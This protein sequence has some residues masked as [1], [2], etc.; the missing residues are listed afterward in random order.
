MAIETPLGKVDILVD[1][2]PVSYSVTQLEPLKVLCPDV[3]KR[4]KIEVDFEPDGKEHLISCILTPSQPVKGYSESGELLECYGYYSE[5]ETIKVSIGIEAET[6]YMYN[7]K[8][9][10]IRVCDR[11]DYDGEFE[12]KNGVFYNSYWV[13][14]IT[15]TSHYVFGIAWIL[16]CN[17][18]TDFQTN[19]G[20]DPTIM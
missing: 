1:G 7:S 3:D 5:D 20:A 14:P 11:Y 12:E 19:F 8:G 17:E 13:L 10:L 4:Y 2:M 9:E 15:K 16:K 6:G 18:E